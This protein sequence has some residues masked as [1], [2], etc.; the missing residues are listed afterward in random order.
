MK[1]YGPY[2][3]KLESLASG[4]F[5]GS[6]TLSRR[7][8]SR[9]LN[10][11]ASEELRALVPLED[12]RDSGAFFTP[13]RMGR[14][15]IKHIGSWHSAPVFFDPACGAGDLLVAVADQLPVAASLQDT[16]ELWGPL[17]WGWDIHEEF[18]RATR[19]RLII[20]A[21]SRCPKVTRTRATPAAL[22]PNISKRNALTGLRFGPEYSHMLT[23]PPFTARLAPKAC[24]W[25]QGS[26]SAAAVFVA[27]AL[28]HGPKGA[29]VLAVL[30]DVLRT[31]PRYCAWREHVQAIA[32]VRSVDAVGR[33]D[34]WT[35]IDV[36]HLGVELGG[37]SSEP[38]AAWVQGH[39]ESRL[40]DV[41]EV[42]VGAVVP[43][44]HAKRGPVQR[45]LTTD[46]MP[47]WASVSA[48]KLPTRR[49]SGKIVNPP[50]VAVRRM[51][52]PEDSPRAVATIIR[53]REPV[54][55]ENHVIILVP[56]EQTLKACEQ[57]VARLRHSGTTDWLLRTNRCRH[58]T[59]S[60]LASIPWS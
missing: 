4:L 1:S 12:R 59:S 34:D 38:H 60:A 48:S 21:A 7:R 35:D 54:A 13:S 42:S 36:F 8:F 50:F 14:K 40:D 3:K 18:V 16:L 44:R 57:I 49:F 43:H 25:A 19:A 47:R 41:V 26:V 32:S 27:E 31:G 20:A 37:G 33:F 58:L 46:E 10:G 56:H 52:R 24:T 30:P 53:G 9:T 28:E 11:Q 15:L 29:Q 23:N 39:T 6:T 45:Y 2:V 55:V 17:L 51:S 5:H 22:L